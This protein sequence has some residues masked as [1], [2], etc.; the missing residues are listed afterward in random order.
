MFDLLIFLIEAFGV[1]TAAESYEAELVEEL[2][3]FSRV[4]L[5]ACCYFLACSICS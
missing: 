5:I 3:F 2:F 1:S 4:A